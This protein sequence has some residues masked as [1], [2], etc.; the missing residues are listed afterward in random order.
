MLFL[1]LFLLTVLTILLKIKNDNK[2]ISNLFSKGNV[3][4][5]YLTKNRLIN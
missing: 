1:E 3:G 2:T 5:T 4:V